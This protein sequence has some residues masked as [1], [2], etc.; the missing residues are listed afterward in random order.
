LSAI[1]AQASRELDVLFARALAKDPEARP[2]DVEEWAD[3]LAETL[4]SLHID[5]PAWRIAGD[6]EVVSG[7]DDEETAVST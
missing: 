4:D 2:A 1:L 5:R 7:T 6:P 3:E